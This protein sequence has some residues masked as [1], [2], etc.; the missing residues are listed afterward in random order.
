MNLLRITLDK[1]SGIHASS[2]ILMGISERCAL[3]LLVCVIYYVIYDVCDP[4]YR[5]TSDPDE[6]LLSR[7]WLDARR[8]KVKSR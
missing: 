2:D 1:F 6:I 7:K 5:D 3:H 8:S 4:E